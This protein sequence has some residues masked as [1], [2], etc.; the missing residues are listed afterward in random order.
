MTF[1]GIPGNG[2]A[3]VQSQYFKVTRIPPRMDDEIK[4]HTL[5]NVRGL[6]TVQEL[7]NDVKINLR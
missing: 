7:N 5:K 2:Q 3:A 4:E 6:L 1:L